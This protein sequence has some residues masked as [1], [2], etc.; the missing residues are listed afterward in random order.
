MKKEKESG[1]RTAISYEDH[2]LVIF[3]RGDFVRL[4]M[5]MSLC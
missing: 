4:E 1:C 2:S 5:M 3:D